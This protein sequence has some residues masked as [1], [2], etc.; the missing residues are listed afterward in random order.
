MNTQEEMTIHMLA[1]MMRAAKEAGVELTENTEKI[2]RARVRMGLPITVC[3]CAS[4]DTDRGCISPK[5][6]KEIN[7]VNTC[8]CNCYCKKGVNNVKLNKGSS[9]L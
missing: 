7:E 2:A 4:S 3:P 6:L 1:D 8:H 5:C 9:A